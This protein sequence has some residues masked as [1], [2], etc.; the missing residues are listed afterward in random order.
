MFTVCP[1]SVSPPLAPDDQIERLS[2]QLKQE[3]ELAK[4]RISDRYGKLMEPRTFD[5]WRPRGGG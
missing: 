5:E 1:E 3:V 4:E 2:E